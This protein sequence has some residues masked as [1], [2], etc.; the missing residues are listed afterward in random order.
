M[1]ELFSKLIG[2]FISICIIVVITVFGL[3]IWNEFNKE[4]VITEPEEFLSTFSTT[5]GTTEDVQAPPVQ[6]I[7]GQGNQELTEPT[8]NYNNIKVNKYLYNQLDEN[9]KYIYNAFEENKEQMKTGT[10]KINF[11]DYFSDMLN[12]QNGDTLM[13][14]CYQT[15]IE[16]YTYD[17]PD[18]FYLDPTKMYLNIAE[19]TY[20]NGEKKYNVYINCGTEGSYIIKEFSSANQVNN[21]LAQVEQVKNGIL[22]QRT[23]NTLQDIKMVHDYLIDTIEY[24]E[25][26]SKENIYNMYGALINRTCVCEG[27]ARSFKYILESMGVQCILRVGTGTNLKGKTERHAWNY[28]EYGGRWYAVD[29]TW[30][31]PVVIGNGRVR[32]QDKTKYFMK[33]GE[34]FNQAH[35]PSNAFIEGGKEFEYPE[36]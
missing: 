2:V 24:D 22:S 9:E 27:Y 35:S 11:G 6:I 25:S 10:A 34:E 8:K 15:A 28:V 32:E 16:A 14:R 19:T 36:I 26:L 5:A 13:Q 17:N 21:A 4:E 30:D 1:K 7:E 20:S 23:G 12:N 33:T 29:V 3:I 31:D 18:V